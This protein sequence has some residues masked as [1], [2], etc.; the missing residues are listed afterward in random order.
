MKKRILKNFLLDH[1]FYTMVYFISNFLIG[2]FY[3][4]SVG[5]NIELIYPGCISIFLYIIF[6]TYRWVSYSEFN[7]KV[8]RLEDN[9][10]YQIKTHSLEEKEL[11]QSITNIHQSYMERISSINFQDESKKRF[12]SQ[13]IH[14]M[15]T[16][17]SV[18]DLIL[19]K[20]IKEEISSSKALEDINE[21]NIKLLNKLEQVLNLLRLEDFTEDYVPDTVDL[22]ATL[23]KVINN[24]KNQ[25]IYSKVYPKLDLEENSVKV[26]S[27]VK[28]NEAMLD[29]IVSNAIKYS[30]TSQNTKNVYFNIEYQSGKVF[31]KI[32]DEGIGIPEYDIDRVF[33]PFFTG[34]NGR[35]YENATGIGLY[36][37]SQVAK[38]LGHNIAV[39][40]KV[41]EGTEVIITYLSK[42]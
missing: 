2:L 4:I 6:I 23:R 26:L 5:G 14:N 1:L 12:V 25:F 11:V 34:E 13:W 20:T 33:N 35:N 29:Q 24:R 8:K 30:D 31:L 27:D 39:N 17:I 16:P 37:A 3:Y 19:Q 42:L 41:G 28:W 22:V 10:N 21:E 18:I 9:M 32:K 15:K 36:F 7:I 38:R 40:S